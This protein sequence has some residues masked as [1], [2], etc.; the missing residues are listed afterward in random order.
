MLNGLKMVER[1]LLK[2]NVITAED[3]VTQ[4][5]FYFFLFFQKTY[6]MAGHYARDCREGGRRDRDQRSRGGYDRRYTIFLFLKTS[7]VVCVY[8]WSV[9]SKI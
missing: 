4:Q 8:V 7:F 1:D 3:Q 5:N 2:M 9:S 6:L